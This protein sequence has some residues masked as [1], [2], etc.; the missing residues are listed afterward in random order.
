MPARPSGGCARERPT[1][2]SATKVFLWASKEGKDGAKRQFW[3]AL[4][5]AREGDVIV[6]YANGNI[7]AVSTVE[8]D[9]VDAKSPEGLAGSWSEDG[10]LVRPDYRELDSPIVLASIPVDAR[11]AQGARFTRDGS[12]QQGYFFPLSEQFVGRLAELFPKLGLPGEA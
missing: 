4:A 5:D 9:A 12:V 8:A 10:W 6:H 1:R 2:C 7:R 3:T 11:L